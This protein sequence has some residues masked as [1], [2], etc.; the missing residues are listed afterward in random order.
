PR[1]PPTSRSTASAF[2]EAAEL[3]RSG[4]D[5]LRDLRR[6]RIPIGEDRFLAIG[7]ISRVSS[8]YVHPLSRT[9]DTIRIISARWATKSGR[10]LFRYRVNEST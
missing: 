7:P 1:T 3:F 4:V 2:D 9:K 5:Y 8:F 6:G 10:E